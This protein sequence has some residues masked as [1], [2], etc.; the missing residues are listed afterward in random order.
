MIKEKHDK[1]IVHFKDT[2]FL[3]FPNEINAKIIVLIEANIAT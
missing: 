3:G 2:S 1:V